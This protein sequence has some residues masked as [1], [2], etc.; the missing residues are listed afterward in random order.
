MATKTRNTY[1]D[2]TATIL[3]NRSSVPNA[4][5]ITVN[6]SSIDC[7]KITTG[8][9]KTA[10][11]ATINKIR[12]LC[13]HVNVNHWSAFGPTVRTVVGGV[14]TNSDPTNGLEGDFG[15]Y[16]H[17]AVA[18]HF[19]SKGSAT[20]WVYSSGASH[21][22]R[23]IIDI[24]E[25][26]Y[27]DIIS[28]N[29]VTHVAFSVW[30]S[31]TVKGY[32]VKPI[33]GSDLGADNGMNIID[34]DY[35]ASNRITVTG[36]TSSATYTCKIWFID[37]GTWDYTGANKVCN[38]P[39]LEDWTETIRI[40]LPTYIYNSHDAHTYTIVSETFGTGSGAGAGY[41]A[42]EGA[43]CNHT[44]TTSLQV[45]AWVKNYDE[46]ILTDIYEIRAAT[47]YTANAEIHAYLNAN[48]WKLGGVQLDLPVATENLICVVFF[49]GI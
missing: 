38:V 17:S 16:N 48:I 6:A 39:G 8:K 19:N 5:D 37:D 42:W 13:Q 36:I 33:E 41:L 43:I 15:G 23:C 29:D 32:V 46:D 18:P 44:Y 20:S 45:T 14:L 24:G 12:G 7:V 4:A 25:L 11:S 21:T 34:F 9:I 26:L 31:S 40:M 27:T 22:F 28:A 49:N 2:Y 47:P 30:I 35:D 3:K 1:R 10:L